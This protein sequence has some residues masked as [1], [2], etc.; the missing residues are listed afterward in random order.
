MEKAGDGNINWVRR[1]RTPTRSWVV[2]QARPALERFPEYR[3]STHRILVEA[4]YYETVAAFDGAGV[5]PRVLAFDPEARVLVLEDLGDVERLDGALA[6]GADATPAARRVAAFLGAVHACSRGLDLAERFRNDEMQRLH[7]DHVFHLPYREN[8]LPLSPARR[9]R[10]EAIRR[11]RALVE[12][13]DAAYARYLEP[14]GVLVHGDVQAGN[15]LLAPR[16]AVLLD[17][18]IAHLGDPA[19]DVGVFLAHLLGPGLARGATDLAALETA[20]RAYA[21]AAGEAAPP[22]RDAARIAGIELLRRAIGAAG[23]A[24][25]ESDAAVE[26]VIDAGVSLTA[27]PP[28]CLD[29]L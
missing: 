1:A 7:G 12:R 16:G 20:W 17:A 28:D 29:D 13:I 2:K 25:S 8:N 9:A 11:D 5:C 27:S 6:C 24:W 14:R 23:A 15:V 26:R 18:E 19:F 10:A 4:R 22:F 3:V 21:D